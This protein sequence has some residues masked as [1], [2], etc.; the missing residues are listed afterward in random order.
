[1]W[2][3]HHNR[4]SNN[5][6]EQ[7]AIVKALETTEKP[8][9]NEYI[10]RTVTVHTVSRITHQSLKNTKNHA[11]LIEEMRKKVIALENHNWRIILP[12]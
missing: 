12:G 7:L 11:Y 1:M 6:A 3:T 5:Q 8:Q 2:F 10:P 4:C 9:M